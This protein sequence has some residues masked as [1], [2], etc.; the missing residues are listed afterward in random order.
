[1]PLNQVVASL[2]IN[3]VRNVLISHEMGLGKTLSSILFVEMNKDF[4]K[5]F[6]ITPNSLKFNFYNEIEKFTNSK[7]HIIG[8][9]KN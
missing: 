6:V 5:V 2:F 3:K 9:R 8:W 1:M 7:A 4:E